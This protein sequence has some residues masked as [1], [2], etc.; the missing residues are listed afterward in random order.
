MLELGLILI[1]YCHKY[2]RQF[3]KW[4]AEYH[5]WNVKTLFF[6]EIWV[7]CPRYPSLFRGPWTLIVSKAPHLGWLFSHCVTRVSIWINVNF[8]MQYIC[9]MAGYCPTPLVIVYVVNPSL[10]IMLW[11]AAMEDLPLYVMMR[12]RIL[13]LN[14]LD[15]YIITLLLNHHCSHSQEKVLLQP[16]PTSKMML[17][18]LKHEKQ[19][20][21]DMT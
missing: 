18:S 20:T 19:D 3:T 8:G 14:G 12:L 5:K 9:V 7:V 17:A 16:L 15:R 2:V 4:M 11:F 13:Q 6:Q 10:L 1:L 21:W